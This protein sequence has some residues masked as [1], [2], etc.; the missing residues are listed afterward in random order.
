MARDLS[1]DQRTLIRSHRIRERILITFYM[2]EGT[3]RFCD[4]AEDMSDGTYT[5]IGASALAKA[6][7]IRSGSGF[8]AEGM[9]LTVDGTRLSQSGFTDPASFFRTILTYNLA[10]RRVDFSLGLSYPDQQLIQLVLPIYAGK[11]NYLRLVDQKI[12][13]KPSASQDPLISNLE[14]Y[15]DSLSMRYQWATGRVRTH[16]DQLLTD[17]TDMFFS[18][19]QN[20]LKNE[21]TL[22][23]GKDNPQKPITAANVIKN[24]TYAVTVPYKFGK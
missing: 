1:S 8:S 10:N 22:Y 21:Q 11:I 24:A 15:I 6:T 2:D 17:P 12:G 13:F 20:N 5:Y 19:V 3:Y 7:D 4:D 16:Q 9:T 18:F 14:I 23:W